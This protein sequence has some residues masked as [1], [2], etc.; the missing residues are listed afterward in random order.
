MAEKA[1]EQS[2]DP[3]QD[4][5][6]PGRKKLLLLG[7]GLILLIALSITLTTVIFSSVQPDSAASDQAAEPALAAREAALTA[8]QEQVARQAEA[9]A[10]LESELKTLQ[11]NSAAR[12]L[13]E[14]LISQEESFQLFLVALKE[15]MG[16]I[17]NMV[18]GSRTWLEHYEGRLDEV[19]GQSRQR[20]ESLDQA[21]D[22]AD[23]AR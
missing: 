6:T 18:R 15:G 11:H 1:A 7:G 22:T 23:L 12:R 10:R 5:K 2:P 17:A 19:L 9:I 4:S 21:T 8:L 3:E 14:V 16:D 13:Q 20:A